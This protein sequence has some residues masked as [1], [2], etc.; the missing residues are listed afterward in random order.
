MLSLK[1]FA[2]HNQFTNCPSCLHPVPWLPEH[3]VSIDCRMSKN[4]S[5]KTLG[6]RNAIDP[7]VTFRKSLVHIPPSANSQA[8]PNLLGNQ[9]VFWEMGQDP[10]CYCTAFKPILVSKFFWDGYSMIKMHSTVL[11][12]RSW[13]KKHTADA[14]L[15]IGRRVCF[16]FEFEWNLLVRHY[17]ILGIKLD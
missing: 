17:Q 13:C 10:G 6:Q 15:H 3:Q 5:P 12:H 16:V 9:R 1:I 11:G 4:H 14:C 7:N 8:W 2:F